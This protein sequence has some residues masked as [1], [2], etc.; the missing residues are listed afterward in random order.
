MAD[1]PLSVFEKYPGSFRLD[2]PDFSNVSKSPYALGVIT[3][4]YPATPDDP[5]VAKDVCDLTVDGQEFKEV[6]IFYHPPKAYDDN[7]KLNAEPSI[8]AFGVLMSSSAAWADF[9]K[10]AGG[11][12]DAQG[13]PITDFP[14]DGLPFKDQAVARGVYSFSVGDEVAVMV[15]DGVPVAVVAFTDG[16]PRRPFD[17]V[18]VEMPPQI[19]DSNDHIT[20]PGDPH[21]PYILQLSDSARSSTPSGQNPGYSPPTGPGFG[22]DGFD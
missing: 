11:L 9:W 3:G 16:I 4:F 12:V 7:W 22:P 2:H 15:K 17:Y 18:Q 10:A 8:H 21:C 1:Q 20:P 5:V 19:A 13:V 14:K 6:P